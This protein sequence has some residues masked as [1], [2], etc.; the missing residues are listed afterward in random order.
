MQSIK[1]DYKP[2][3][4]EHSCKVCNVKYDVEVLPEPGD[5]W[6]GMTIYKYFRQEKLVIDHADL[7]SHATK[8]AE[9]VRESRGQGKRLRRD[10]WPTMRT[11]FEI[12]SRAKYFVHFCSWGMSH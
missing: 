11:F 5:T 6:E 3:P 8:L 2:T 9:V 1:T 12:V 4:N 7:L 10:P